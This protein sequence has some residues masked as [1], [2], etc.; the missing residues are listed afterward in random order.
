[1]VPIEFDTFSASKNNLQLEFSLGKTTIGSNLNGP[2]GSIPSSYIQSVNEM[3][4]HNPT[5]TIV[6][7][8]GVYDSSKSLA[9]EVQNRM[10]IAVNNV[11]N[12]TIPYT[13]FKVI[14]NET[15]NKKN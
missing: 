6:I 7:S 8:E 14:T 1:M 4:D 9:S 2:T 11:I 10:N 12:Q 5:F 13:F 3:I 15:E